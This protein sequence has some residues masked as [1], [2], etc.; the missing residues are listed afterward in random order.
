M[1]NISYLL[2]FFIFLGCGYQPIFSKR[3]FNNILIKNYTFVGDKS[4]NR[5][6]TSFLNLN[7]NKDQKTSPYELILDSKKLIK[8]VAKDSLGNASIYKTNISVNFILKDL[9]NNGKIIK[10]KTFSRS[11]SFSNMTNKFDLSQ[12]QENVETNLVESLAEEIIIF[13]NS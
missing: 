3:D 8:T 10:S 9:A 6:L 1:K 11:F 7:K 12:Y 13:I 2:V 5:K 4:I